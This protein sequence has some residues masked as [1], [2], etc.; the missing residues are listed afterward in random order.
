MTTPRPPFQGD[1]TPLNPAD[2]GTD[3]LGR[4]LS[5]DQQDGDQVFYRRQGEVED[6]EHEFNDVAQYEGEPEVDAVA[7]GAVR[8]EDLTDLELREG[9]TSNPDIAAEEGLT[10]VAPVDPPVVPDPDDPQGARI[11]A[12]FGVSAEDESYDTSNRAELITAE[13]DFEG[14]IREALLAD[15]ATTEYAD[16]IVIGTRGATVVIRGIVDDIDDTDTIVEVISRVSGVDE[17]IE[18]LE[19]RGITD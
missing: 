14:R 15:A 11:A 6:S 7:A 1:E 18:E 5:G 3:E 10:W 13:D 19:V 4:E 2:V 16:Q 8:I 17:V 9:E 12:G